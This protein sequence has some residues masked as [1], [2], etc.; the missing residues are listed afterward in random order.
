MSDYNVSKSTNHNPQNT[1][2]Q[3]EN[4]LRLPDVRKRVGLS[5]SQIYKLISIDAFPRQIRVGER[6]SC[7]QESQINHWIEQRISESRK[8][9]M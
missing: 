6:V 8:E 4:F 1:F 9:T 7:W 3:R 2:R 5:R